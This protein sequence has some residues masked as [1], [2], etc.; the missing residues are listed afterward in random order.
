M[1]R[2]H[3]WR[4][5]QASPP[6]AEQWP[7]NKLFPVFLAS[8]A[9][10]SVPRVQTKPYLRSLGTT[11]FR[12]LRISCWVEGG[13]EGGR[14]PRAPLAVCFIQK[15]QFVS[16]KQQE[17][18]GQWNHRDKGNGLCYRIHLSD[19]LKASWHSPHGCCYLLLWKHT[20]SGHSASPE[21]LVGSHVGPNFPDIQ[22]PCE[23]LNSGPEVSS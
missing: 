17:S 15:W 21:L 23:W 7:L 5:K 20:V 10:I 2:W 12:V 16:F 8:C 3:H 4:E 14:V 13:R 11:H 9:E 22:G 19:N 6:R 18:S 1:Q